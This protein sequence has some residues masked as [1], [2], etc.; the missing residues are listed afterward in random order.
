MQ[1]LVAD[2]GSV[3]Y[4]QT[5]WAYPRPPSLVLAAV[6]RLLLESAPPDDDAAPTPAAGG[7]CSP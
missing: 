2:R 7:H 6:P 4:G 1:R 3:P 5:L